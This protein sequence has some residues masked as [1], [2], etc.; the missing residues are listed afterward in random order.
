MC[1]SMSGRDD[2]SQEGAQNGQYAQFS[3]DLGIYVTMGI[4]G[5]RVASVGLANERPEGSGSDHPFLRRI[6]EHISTGRDDL[7]DIPL[8][9]DVSPFTSQVL[10]AM[11]DVPP[12]EVITYGELARRLGRPGAARAVG[13]ACAS[14]PAIIVVPCHRVVPA[15]GGLGNYSA[16]GGV[17]TKRLLL[18]REGA[19][20]K[21]RGRPRKE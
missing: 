3:E 12:G 8:D 14:N 17:A 6:I 15:G 2:P 18:E 10:E 7:R 13:S 4:R 5:G 19:M 9:L 20:D 21:V 11:R 16:P 1:P